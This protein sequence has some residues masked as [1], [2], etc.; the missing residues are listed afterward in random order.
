MKTVGIGVDIIDNKRFKKLIKDKKFINRIFSKKEIS[1]SKKKLNKINFFSN[2][3]AAKESFAKALGTGFRNKLNF[4]DIEIL[5]DKL[6]KPFYLINNKIKQI[7]K[8]N[9]KIANFELFLSISDEKDYSVA[10]TI[11]Q[12]I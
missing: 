1:A 8:K 2:R 4:K 9:K 10:F 11:I 7:I 5:N 12:K 6:G 3:F